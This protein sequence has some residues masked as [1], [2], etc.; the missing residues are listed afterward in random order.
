MKKSI[1]KAIVFGNNQE[2]PY[3]RLD[4]VRDCFE[5][6]L[7]SEF[8]VQFSEEW[9]GWEHLK[10]LDLCVLYYDMWDSVPPAVSAEV[11]NAFVQQ[12]GG[13]LVVHNGISL[14]NDPQFC[15]LVGA[16]FVAHP[17][18]QIIRYGAIA[19]HAITCDIQPFEVEEEL[20]QF[21]YFGLERFSVLVQG[22]LNETGSNA[23]WVRQSGQGRIAYFA[24]G[25]DRKSLSHQTVRRL[26][27]NT[28]RW[29]AGL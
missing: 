20:Y 21:E 7:S 17:E 13:L 28:A 4:A 19:N 11:L 2:A 23:L 6:I 5:A 3:H 24:I 15:Q 9:F 16:R 26:L 10:K 25:H 14:Q 27:L 12:G 22:R 18:R 8:I 29:C 1:R